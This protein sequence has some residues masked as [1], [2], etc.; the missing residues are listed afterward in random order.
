MFPLDVFSK[1]ELRGTRKS[2][3]DMPDTHYAFIRVTTRIDAQ[4][5]LAGEI[6][7]G[8]QKRVAM[9]P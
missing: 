6:S 9:C 1:H 8:M 3:S 4:Q 7:G 2:A 5:K